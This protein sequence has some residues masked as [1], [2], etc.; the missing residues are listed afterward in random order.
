MTAYKKLDLAFFNKYFF[1]PILLFYCYQWRYFLTIRQLV[2]TTTNC[3][4]TTKPVLWHK[5]LKT[6]AISWQKACKIA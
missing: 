4:M 3:S 2:M 6:P 5:T 1:T